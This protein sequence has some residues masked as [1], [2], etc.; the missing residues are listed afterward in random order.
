MDVV[1]LFSGLLAD[2]LFLTNFFSWFI[3]CHF[4]ILNLFLVCK[5][6]KPLKGAS[7]VVL[8]VKNP[9]TNAGDLRDAVSIPGSGRSPGEGNGNHSSILAWETPW[10]EEPQFSSVQLLSPVQLFA[11]PWTAAHQ[12]S[13]STTNSWACANS[14]PS[15]R[16]CHPTISSS[17]V[18]FSCPQSFPASGSFPESALPIRWPKCWSFS[19]SISPSNEHPG[20]IS[21]RMDWLDLLAV[22]GTLKSLLQLHSSK[23]SI[24]WS[25]EEPGG[26]QSMGS[27]RI[28]CDWS[29][30][31]CTQT[32][33]EK[34]LCGSILDQG[35]LWWSGDQVRTSPSWAKL[36]A[37]EEKQ[38]LSDPSVVQD[39]PTLGASIRGQTVMGELG[40]PWL[41][42]LSLFLS[43]HCPSQ[44]P[45]ATVPVGVFPKCV[46]CHRFASC[47]PYP[48]SCSVW[49]HLCIG[50]SH[51]SRFLPKWNR[52]AHLLEAPGGQGV[53]FAEAAAGLGK[54]GWWQWVHYRR[55][56]LGNGKSPLVKIYDTFSSSVN[57]HPH[58][59][60]QTDS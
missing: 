14:C 47:G 45:V 4:L 46:C 36:W 19:F 54:G 25:S 49:R 27:Q 39:F 21:F 24:L 1:Y 29:N 26:L 57:V 11:T 22:Q 50:G 58:K 18:P 3:H 17:V 41:S 16:C 20:R 10:T 55:L 12:P 51:R 7:Q 5:S 48:S 42:S 52:K 32:P 33:W 34:L 43:T 9:P 40:R 23:A 8:V 37:T 44:M 53:D 35:W 60:F 6:T 56:Q 30:L 13:L 15:S 2:L 28:G 38:R 31:A 59:P